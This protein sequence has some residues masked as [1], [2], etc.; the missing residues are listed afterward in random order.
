MRKNIQV[1]C[2]VLLFVFL[3]TSVP[4]F[5]L[6]GNKVLELRNST[7]RAIWVT[8]SDFQQFNPDNVQWNSLAPGQWGI[9]NVVEG[10]WLHYGYASTNDPGRIEKIHSSN[11]PFHQ[12]YRWFWRVI[13]QGSGLALDADYERAAGKDP[14]R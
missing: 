8:K 5:A 3:L 10:G 6:G 12:D 4:A 11:L 1:F 7:G 13:P 9:W 2:S 14:M